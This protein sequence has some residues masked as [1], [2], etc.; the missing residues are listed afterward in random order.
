MTCGVSMA[1]YDFSNAVKGD[2]F[3]G[4]LFTLTLNGVAIDLTGAT[5]IMDLRLTKTGTSVKRF[6][7]V[8]DEHITISATPTDGTF[9]FN[10]QIIDVDAAD[11][12]YDIQITFADDTVK[13]YIYGR[14]TVI[15][16]VTY[17]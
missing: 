1:R 10:D 11:Y 3:D 8:A 9:T 16:D 12:F 17:N 6:T 14:W 13:T 5:I 15:Q 2:T 7:S 4:V